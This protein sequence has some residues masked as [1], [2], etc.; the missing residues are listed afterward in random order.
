MTVSV[1]RLDAIT[2]SIKRGF[3]EFAEKAAKGREKLV[4][5][6]TGFFETSAAL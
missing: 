6:E 4:E 1:Q 2:Y 3:Q 5:R